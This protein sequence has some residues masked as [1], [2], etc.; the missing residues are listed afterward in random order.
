MRSASG[1]QPGRKTSTVTT[2]W[3]GRAVGSSLGTTFDGICGLTV[4]FSR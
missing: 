4:T 3:T 2:R 1:G